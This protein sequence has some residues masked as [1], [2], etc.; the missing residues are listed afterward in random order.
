MV[1]SL[2]VSGPS[3]V[4]FTRSGACLVSTSGTR[5]TI[6]PWRS[7]LLWAAQGR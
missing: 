7:R 5:S 3:E 1:R 2:S 4:G 6:P